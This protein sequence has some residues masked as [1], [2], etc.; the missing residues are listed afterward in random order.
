MRVTPKL[1][2]PERLRPH[3]AGWDRPG[4]LVDVNAYGTRDSVR[5]EHLRQDAFGGKEAVRHG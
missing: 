2:T 5:G 1:Q 4:A 3:H